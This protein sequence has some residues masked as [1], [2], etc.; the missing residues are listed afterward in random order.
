MKVFYSQ[1]TTAQLS[2]KN[3][4]MSYKNHFKKLYLKT[5]YIEKQAAPG[6][7]T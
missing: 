6:G 7:M 2:V 1:E 5:T 4:W 3:Y